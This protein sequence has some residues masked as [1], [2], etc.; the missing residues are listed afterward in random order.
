M[1]GDVSLGFAGGIV[2]ML[3][4][5]LVS[6]VEDGEVVDK[7]HVSRLQREPQLVP[8]GREMYHVECLGLLLAHGRD[9][10][11]SWRDG[12]SGEDSA[13]CVQPWTVF[14]EVK[15][16]RS[17]VPVGAAAT[18]S[19]PRQN[20]HLVSLALRKIQVRSCGGEQGSSLV[21]DPVV[22]C[23]SANHIWPGLDYLIVDLARGGEA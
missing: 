9:A 13:V 10:W 4:L 21:H 12:R 19:R 2:F 8:L 16:K 20:H 18:T 1:P 11:R 3:I 15:E 5:I 6:G 17:P 23:Q 14:G 7:H 22:S